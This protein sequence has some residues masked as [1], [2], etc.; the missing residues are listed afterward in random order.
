[1]FRKTRIRV[2]V[3]AAL[4]EIGLDVLTNETAMQQSIYVS[5]SIID[6]GARTSDFEE[7]RRAI[8]GVLA[9]HVLAMTRDGYIHSSAMRWGFGDE[10]ALDGMSAKVW[11]DEL[12]DFTPHPLIPHMANVVE[13]WSYTGAIDSKDVSRQNEMARVYMDAIGASEPEDLYD[14]KYIQAMPPVPEFMTMSAFG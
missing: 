14:D 11:S 10:A 3:N 5:Q 9:C 2:L 6:A 13:R 8:R 12:E 4:T 7:I 1:M